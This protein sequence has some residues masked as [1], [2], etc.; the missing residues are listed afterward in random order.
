MTDY[1]PN[2]IWTSKEE[3]FE[4]EP[5]ASPSP[6][7]AS[8]VSPKS[9]SAGSAPQ[10]DA[11]ILKT[12]GPKSSSSGFGGSKPP[13][14]D[15]EEEGGFR[16]KLLI[17]IIIGIGVLA[18]IGFLY[19]I[20]TPVPPQNVAISFSDPGQV[21]VGDPFQLTVSYVNNSQTVLRNAG[22]TL[23]LPV[24]IS[25]V[26]EDPGQRVSEQ[27]VGVLQPG[28]AGSTTFNLIA[29]ANPQSVIHPTAQF[30]YGTQSSPT[31]QFE[32]D[33]QANIVAGNPVVAVVLNAPAQ[34]FSGQTFD[35]TV[36]YMN[37][38]AHA[39]SDAEI[40]LQYPQGFVFQKSSLMPS[41]PQD[42]AW[43]LGALPANASG[44]FTITGSLVGQDNAVAALSGN[45]IVGLQNQ[46]YTI[47]NPAANLTIAL[48]P[49]SIT[50]TLNGS[51]DYI[52]R[53]GDFLNY[54]FTYA[55]NS[56]T[57]FQNV[58]IK[59][60]FAGSML[61]FASLQ[62]NGSFNSITDTVTWYPANTPALASVAPGQSGTV[63]VRV[64]TRT[65]YPIR[66]YGDK[67]FTIA[68]HAKIQ[69]ATVPAG[70]TANATVS[71]TDLLDKVVG[72]A[73]LDSGGYYHEPKYASST[74]S[75]VKNS[76]PFPPKVDTPTTYTI[77]WRIASYAVDVANVVVTATLQSGTTCTGI[78]RSTIPSSTPSCNPANG[79][80]TWQIP[81]LP[82]NTGVVGA[83]AE[84]IIQVQNTPAVNQVGSVV[85]LLGPATLTATDAFTSST[86]TAS[87]PAVD[88]KLSADASLVNQ[89]GVVVP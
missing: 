71:V 72:A 27:S 21:F 83:P 86:L 8:A 28:Q 38:A 7:S 25:F 4:Y 57:T 45:V 20:L 80:V 30:V 14:E 29:T 61:N 9:A 64:G 89:N 36:T 59:A 52:V 62:S 75:G 31:A 68:A 39:L 1:N 16:K 10:R 67:D 6:K 76:G 17:E 81:S 12:P 65:A 50:G 51:L 47:A 19:Y 18:L 53:Q 23:T 78:L 2:S 5:P 41:S 55:N 42:N 37:N 24:G 13:V 22:L 11:P 69:S 74:L 87:A 3:K 66:F 88:T 77:H 60:S 34:V 43:D 79:Q 70:T 58:E 40:Q 85:T 32:T 44:T 63:A 49:L 84:A 73:S 82:A 56:S 15:S 33:G 35:A 54:V 48:S 26:G 46:V